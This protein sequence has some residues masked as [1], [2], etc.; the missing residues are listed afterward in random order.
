VV[1]AVVRPAAA[2]VAEAAEDGNARKKN[3]LRS[4][5]YQMKPDDVQGSI[6]MTHI[7]D[8]TFH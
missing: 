5:A 3:A 8:K 4:G 6:E 1:A 2:V 7:D